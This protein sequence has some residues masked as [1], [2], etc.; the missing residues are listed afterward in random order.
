MLISMFAFCSFFLLAQKNDTLDIGS[1]FIPAGY[2]GCTDNIS[3][4]DAWSINP[5]S[6]SICYK[7]SFSTSCPKG[8]AGV[9][10][11]NTADD[12]G[13]NW[14][15][16]PGTNLSKN[17]FTKLSFWARGENGGEVV[18]FGCGGID[19]TISQPDIFKYK[20]S[21]QKTKLSEKAVLTREWIRFTINLRNKDL[22]SVIGGFYWT[23]SWTAN[24]SGLIFY[25]DDIILE[26]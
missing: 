21:F 3:I 5:H 9:Y 14:G 17:G 1:Q 19:N 24:S 25:L 4:Q 12:S 7:I 2:M 20:D 23:A 22:S 18:E 15:Q 26:R 11:T 16:Y 10:W 13:A 6:P 8:W